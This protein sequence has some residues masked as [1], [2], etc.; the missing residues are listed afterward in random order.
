MSPPVFQ[1][2]RRCS[3]TR[4]RFGR[5]SELMLSAAGHKERRLAC[6]WHGFLTAD[7]L[8]RRGALGKAPLLQTASVN[9][10][11]RPSVSSESEAASATLSDPT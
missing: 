11:M 3:G 4:E 9:L 2:A 6:L 7:E 10:Q 1:H 5:I 8:G